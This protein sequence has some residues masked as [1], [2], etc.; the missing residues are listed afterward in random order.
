[1]KAARQTGRPVVRQAGRQTDTR[2]TG[3]HRQTDFRVDRQAGRQTVGQAGRQADGGTEV[4][5][6][7]EILKCPG[8]R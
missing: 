1:M 5:R 7:K 8:R 3:R 2:P 6:Q 4:S